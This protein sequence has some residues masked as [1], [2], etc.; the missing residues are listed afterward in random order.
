MGSVVARLTPLFLAILAHGAP[1]QPS[2]TS[3]PASGWSREAIVTLIGVFV[4]VI[5]IGITLIA[6]PKMRSTVKRE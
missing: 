3:A 2:Q 4:A 6:S 5:G 1:L